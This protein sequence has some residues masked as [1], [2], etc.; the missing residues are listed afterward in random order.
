MTTISD[1]TLMA[2]LDN[3]LPPDERARV[4][5]A[6]VLDSALQA[7][8]RR[9]ERVREL[10]SEAFDPALHRS[11]PERLV[12]A[13]LRTPIPMQWHVQR[14]FA[15]PFRGASFGDVVR[16]WAPL[17]APAMATLVIGLA[18]GFFAGSGDSGGLAQGG[19]VADGDLAHALDRQLASDDV[20][21]GPRVAVSFRARDGRFC[22]SFDMGAARDNLAGVACRNEN[23]WSIVAL[24]AA[25]PRRGA[26]ELAGSGMPDVVRQSVTQMM[27]GEALNAEGERRAREAG[28]R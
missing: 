12:D 14:A 23:T 25:E 6:L 15:L 18:I 16:A 26:Y 17:L 7:R 22:R 24:A 5:A 10:L 20:R 2:Y 27:T 3:E 28:W 9:Q 1:E 19:L 13:A 21:S 11:V 8:L 4:N